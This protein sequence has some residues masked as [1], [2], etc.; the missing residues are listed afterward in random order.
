MA[1][2]VSNEGGAVRLTSDAYGSAA[3][4]TISQ[5]VDELGIPDNEYLGID[6]A[7]TINGESATGDGRVLT[8]DSDNANTGGLTIRVTLTAAQLIAQGQDQGTVKIIQGVA[9]QLSRVLASMTD[10]TEGLIATREGAIED[11]IQANIEQIER[12][13]RRLELK[14][15]SL[16][17]QFTVMEI[18]LAELNS[19][20]SFLGSQLA[21]LSAQL[22][23]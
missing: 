3:G 9:S 8:G 11:T 4:F 18:T 10:P 14:R 2:S 12:L 22:R 6:A 1:I 20:G 5:T 23:R 19:M 17:R 16:Q 13:E 21:S 15:S 7:G